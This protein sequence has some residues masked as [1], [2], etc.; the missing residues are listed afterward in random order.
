MKLNKRILGIIASFLSVGTIATSVDAAAYQ[1]IYNQR[2]QQI[3]DI[4]I[5]LTSEF[6]SDQNK[7]ILTQSL[8]RLSESESKANRRALRSVLEEEQLSLASIQDQLVLTES[9][10]AQKE[11]AQ[12]A[13]RVD[14]LTLQAEEPFIL[15][16]DSEQVEELKVALSNLE[17]VESV[18]PMRLLAKEAIDLEKQLTSNQENLIEIVDGLQELNGQAEKLSKQKYLSYDDKQQL[19]NVQEENEKYFE[20][21]DDLDEVDTRRKNS[22]TVI[23]RIETKQKETEKDFKEYEDDSKELIKSTNSLLSEGD[24]LAEESEALNEYVASLNLALERE[25]Y[26][27][28][29]LATNYQ[30]LKSDYDEFLGKSDE[31]IAIAKEKAEKEAAEKAERER[32]ETA[33]QEAAREAARIEAAANNAASNNTSATS[34]TNNTPPAATQSGDWYVAPAGYK[35]LKVESGLTYGQVKIPGNFSLITNEQAASY[36]PGRGNGWAKQ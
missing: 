24:L 35:Y 5:T 25:A 22:S 29:D 36:S 9:E 7:E 26:S 14:E 32:E 10:V 18:I 27:P 3:I 34:T 30:L 19:A 15:R 17:T 20:D 1:E 6:I 28:G 21:A 4:E 33:K 11:R 13:K 16:D 8:T 31:R 12:L 23:S 2:S